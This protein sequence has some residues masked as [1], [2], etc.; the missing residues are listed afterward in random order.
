MKYSKVQFF[1]NNC[2]KEMMIEYHHLIGREFKVCSVDCLHEM[3]LKRASSIL[4][5]EYKPKVK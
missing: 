2:G 5:E 4:N 1:C 3:E